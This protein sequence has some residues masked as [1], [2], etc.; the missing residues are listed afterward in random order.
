MLNSKRTPTR[1]S[2]WLWFLRPSLLSACCA[3]TSIVLIFIINV[4]NTINNGNGDHA[5]LISFSNYHIV[6]VRIYM[7]AQST[8]TAVHLQVSRINSLV[9][10]MPLT[11]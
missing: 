2:H 1:L 11:N 3:I 5:G 6:D 4:A 7:L 10:G 9:Y 8:H